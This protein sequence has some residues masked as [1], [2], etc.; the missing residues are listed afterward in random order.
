MTYKRN[1][2]FNTIY[3]LL[4]LTSVDMKIWKVKRRGEGIFKQFVI[5][6]Y[7]FYVHCTCTLFTHNI[8]SWVREA[9]KKVP[10]LV[11]R[12]LR[13]GGGGGLN[14][15]QQRKKNIFWRFGNFK[16]PYNS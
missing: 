16:K 8:N 2:N 9:V 12:P 5:L 6:M 4:F 7:N 1:I 3:E 13:V 10:P 14:A 11:V 15:G